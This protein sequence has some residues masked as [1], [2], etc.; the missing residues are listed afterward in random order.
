MLDLGATIIVMT[1]LV[2]LQLGLGN[3]KPIVV[4]FK[5]ADRFIRHP[6]QIVEDLLVQI[7]SIIILV[8]FVVKE[9]EDITSK[10]IEHTILLGRPIVAISNTIIIVQKG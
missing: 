9:I 4:S 1:Y 10:D 2:Y 3:L 5:L 7:K 8:D 6:K